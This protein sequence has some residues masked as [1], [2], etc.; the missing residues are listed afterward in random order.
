[1]NSARAKSQQDQS[2]SIASFRLRSLDLA[3]GC[4]KFVPRTSAPSWENE[5]RNRKN[6]RDNAALIGSA[7]DVGKTEFILGST[8]Y[9]PRR[10]PTLATLL[11]H[12]VPDI[13][14]RSADHQGGARRP[15]RGY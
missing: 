6:C 11:I 3:P 4:A 15:C 10:D 2:V 13:T 5:R 8:G 1:M 7:I 12:S 14:G 9:D